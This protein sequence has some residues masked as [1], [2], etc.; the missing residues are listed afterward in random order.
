MTRYSMGLGMG[1]EPTRGCPTVRVLRRTT[2]PYDTPSC[3]TNKRLPN[4]EGIETR[5]DL[6]PDRGAAANKRL[7]NCEGIETCLL[8]PWVGH[9]SLTRGCPTARVLRPEQPQSFLLHW[10]PNKRL[11]NCEGIETSVMAQKVGGAANTNKRLP[12]CEGIETSVT[13]PATL[14]ITH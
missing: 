9:F 4:C 7:P 5:R 11:P 1:Q 8:S 10:S 6:R 2:V 12:N 13:M 14:R 3:T